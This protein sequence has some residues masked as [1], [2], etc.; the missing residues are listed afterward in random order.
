MGPMILGWDYFL[1]GNEE[2]K[3]RRR[4]LVLCA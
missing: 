1:T 4:T 3:G 2:T